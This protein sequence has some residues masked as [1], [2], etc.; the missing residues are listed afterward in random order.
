MERIVTRRKKIIDRTIVDAML[1]GNIDFVSSVPC[2]LLAGVLDD[3]SN[4]SNDR[5]RKLIHLPVTREEEGVGVCAGAYLGGSR[6]ALL[7]QNSGLGNSTNALLSLTNLYKLGLFLLVSFRGRVGEEDIEAQMPMG[8]ATEK[9]LSV[10]GAK[11]RV[12]ERQTDVGA[13]ESL[14]K[15]AYQKE[16]I[17]AALVTSALWNEPGETQ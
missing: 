9:I 5:R 14:A 3:I 1:R 2:S 17:T 11:S 12:I 8:G 15:I 6:P 16:Q 4:F 7:M 10:V 13:I